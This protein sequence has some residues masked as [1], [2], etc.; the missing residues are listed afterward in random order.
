MMKRVVECLALLPENVCH[1]F[2]DWC[3][4]GQA[5]GAAMRWLRRANLVD[6]AQILEEACDYQTLYEASAKVRTRLNEMWP[7]DPKVMLQQKDRIQAFCAVNMTN[8]ALRFALKDEISDEKR[9]RNIA[10]FAIVVVGV[11]EATHRVD[12]AIQK[13]AEAEQDQKLLEICQRHNIDIAALC[14]QSDPSSVL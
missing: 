14:D 8:N 5:K 6:L 13:A 2:D 7:D 4:F 10:G 11:N 3:I 12:E 1:E 9:S